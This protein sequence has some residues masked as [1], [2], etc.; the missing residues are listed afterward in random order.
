MRYHKVKFFGK[1]APGPT[2]GHL[3]LNH[4]NR[5]AEV[6]PENQSGQK[7]NASRRRT[8]VCPSGR[9]ELCLGA[10]GRVLFGRDAN[11]NVVASTTRNYGNMW[12]YFHRQQT[13]D[14]W[15]K[16]PGQ[17]GR[18]ERGKRC[19][20]S[21]GGEWRRGRFRAHQRRAWARAGGYDVHAQVYRT[22]RRPG[23]Q[24]F[25]YIHAVGY[26]FPL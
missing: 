23:G 26:I 14:Q 12:H 9:S 13:K 7:P 3:L 21:S 2:H 16:V 22:G 20:L 4:R 17:L 24:D 15:E 19:E 10:G 11:T 18:T 8:V 6:A 25:A 5:A 1:S